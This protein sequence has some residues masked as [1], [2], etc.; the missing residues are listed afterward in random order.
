VFP[1]LLPKPLTKCVDLLQLPHTTAATG[2]LPCTP[3]RQPVAMM[4]GREGGSV[5]A[6]GR[7]GSSG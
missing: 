5:H 4:C 3:Q 6:R 2:H 7:G 1:V